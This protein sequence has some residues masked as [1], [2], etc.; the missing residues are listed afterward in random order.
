MFFG[1]TKDR[2]FVN[3]FFMVNNGNERSLLP[4]KEAGFSCPN[5]IL[6]Y[7]LIRVGGVYSHTPP[8]LKILNLNYQSSFSSSVE[9]KTYKLLCLTKSLNEIKVIM[10]RK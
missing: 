2:S 5:H 9:E 4:V 6:T 10:L 8:S 7:L 3:K 1:L